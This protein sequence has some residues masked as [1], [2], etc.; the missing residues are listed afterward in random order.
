MRPDQPTQVEL[1]RVDAEVL[2][3]LVTAATIGADPLD[4]TPPALGEG[5]TTERIDW[6]R[7]YHTECF[8]GFEGGAD[9]ET[10]A[11]RLDGHVVGASRLRRTTPNDPSELEWGIWL[12]KRARGLG[13][14]RVVLRLAANRAVLSGAST[15]VART[16]IGNEP[17]LRV[18][19]RA[20]ATI[21]HSADGTVFARLELSTHPDHGFDA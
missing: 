18:L 19:Q 5:W 6:L 13:L 20:N 7:A 15:L 21:D 1:V 4:V 3:D 14:A 10:C 2:A 16:T 11:I 8:P 12:V 17:A 9:E